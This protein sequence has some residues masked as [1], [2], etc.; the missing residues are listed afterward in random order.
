[1]RYKKGQENSTKMY[2]S[3]ITVN[4]EASDRVGLFSLTA[5]SSCHEKCV[6]DII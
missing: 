6:N 1:M 4:C 5:A 3:Q 2:I